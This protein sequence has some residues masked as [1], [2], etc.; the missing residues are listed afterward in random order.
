MEDCSGLPSLPDLLDELNRD[1]DLSSL[2]E[3]TQ[4][5]LQDIAADLEAS[6][7]KANCEESER[8]SKECL[9]QMVGS[10]PELVESD[11]CESIEHPQ[12]DDKLE[13]EIS[14]YLLLHHDYFAKR[15]NPKTTTHISKRRQQPH[16]MKSQN[17]DSKDKL[18]AKRKL[19]DILPKIED[20]L[21]LSVKPEIIV[22]SCESDLVYGTYDKNTNC[23]VIVNNDNLRLEE[24]VTEVTTSENVSSPISMDYL[25]TPLNSDC[26]RDS[27]SPA[28]SSGYE[29]IGSPSSEMDIW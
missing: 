18:N 2:E 11:R 8:T 17:N 15:N 4:S 23:I 13:C 3:I 9:E 28:P 6:A 12:K 10:A 5:L 26:S 22:D 1:V 21:V 24:A 7:Q 14:P 27:L 25:Q 20:P 19:K 29:S 16:S